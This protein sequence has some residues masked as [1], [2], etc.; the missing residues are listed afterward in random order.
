M[1]SEVTEA[2]EGRPLAEGT[3][4]LQKRRGRAQA[5]TLSPDGWELLGL[6]HKDAHTAICPVCSYLLV[7]WPTTKAE[8]FEGRDT[9][10]VS[11]TMSVSTEYLGGL[12]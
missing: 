9:V 3:E 8:P 1:F 2:Q 12:G 7:P 4:P 5:S 11:S 6:Q 10:S